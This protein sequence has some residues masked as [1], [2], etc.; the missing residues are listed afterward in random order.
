MDEEGGA[1]GRFVAE[2]GGSAWAVAGV[3]VWGATTAAYRRAMPAP[4][5]G[6]SRLGDQPKA[7]AAR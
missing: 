1:P 3:V 6:P 7:A 4:H 5:S 2:V